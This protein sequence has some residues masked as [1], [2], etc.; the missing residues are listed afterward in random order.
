MQPPPAF[1]GGAPPAGIPFVPPGAGYV[2][3]PAMGT[4]GATAN[5][6][7]MQQMQTSEVFKKQDMKPAD[8]DPFRMYW[9]REYD[10]TWSQRNRMTIDSGDIGVCRVSCLL[11]FGKAKKVCSG[12]NHA[13]SVS[14][15][16]TLHF[17]FR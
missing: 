5:E 17:I 11:L 1:G 10:N 7:H 14:G 9:V 12:I 4:F 16:F 8:D 2:P 13:R 6:I 3:Q 15:I